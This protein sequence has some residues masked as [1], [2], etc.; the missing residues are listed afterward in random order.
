M[1]HGQNMEFRGYGHPTIMRVSRKY[2]Y[3]GKKIWGD[4]PFWENQQCSCWMKLEESHRCSFHGHFCSPFPSISKVGTSSYKSFPP[5]MSNALPIVASTRPE[6]GQVIRQE[7]LTGSGENIV[8]SSRPK[9][10]ILSIS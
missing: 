8:L 2:G 5:K 4:H 10:R 7:T 6:P 1:C 3:P 9:V